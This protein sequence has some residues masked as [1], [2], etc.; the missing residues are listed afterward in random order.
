MDRQRALF[1]KFDR[2]F[3]AVRDCDVCI[4]DTT[5]AQRLRSGDRGLVNRASDRRPLVSMVR[6]DRRNPVHRLCT[7]HPRHPRRPCWQRLPRWCRRNRSPDHLG[8][9]GSILA[10]PV[11]LAPL[12][13]RPARTLYDVASYWGPMLITFTVLTLAPL[14]YAGLKGRPVAQ[15]GRHA[16]CNCDDRATHRVGDD[17]R[18][19]WLHRPW[20]HDELGMLARPD[21][22]HAAPRLA[23][24]CLRAT[25]QRQCQCVDSFPLATPIHRAGLMSLVVCETHLR[26][27]LSR[28]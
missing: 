22:D 25:L 17:L 9:L 21:T 2:I 12:I 28:R 24:G 3:R 1:G 4:R 16:R 15:V 19:Q 20:R 7:R 23:S 13:P 8:D 11:D 14:A 10:S 5:K 26:K 18:I 27:A 6:I